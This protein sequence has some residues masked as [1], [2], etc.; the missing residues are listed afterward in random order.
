MIREFRGKMIGFLPV[1]HIV[2]S[3]IPLYSNPAE[4]KKP[5]QQVEEWFTIGGMCPEIGHPNGVS[6]EVR[7]KA[8]E[9]RAM[10]PINIP[11]N[12]FVEEWEKL[13]PENPKPRIT[14]ENLDRIMNT[15]KPANYKD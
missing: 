14:D 4:P 11:K 12:R 2:Y 9:L 5:I 8:D 7:A 10:P 6:E 1:D 15:L 3:E 13:D